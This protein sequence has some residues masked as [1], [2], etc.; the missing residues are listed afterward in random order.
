MDLAAAL[1]P[2]VKALEAAGITLLQIDEPIFSTGMA[3]LAIGKQA[4]ET[5]H[6]NP[7]DSNLYACLRKFRECP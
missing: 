4:I 5:H 3:D 2:E 6:D 1:V 7:A